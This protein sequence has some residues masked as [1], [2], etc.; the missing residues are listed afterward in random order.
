MVLVS[1]NSIKIVNL[2]ILF[3]Q[4][5][6]LNLSFYCN[7]LHGQIKLINFVIC[8]LQNFVNFNVQESNYF[9]KPFNR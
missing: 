7:R 9:F 4:Y 2:G 1:F 3:N 6:I 5:Y 8:K